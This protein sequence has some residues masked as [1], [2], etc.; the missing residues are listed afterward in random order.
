MLSVTSMKSD[1]GQDAR[2]GGREGPRRF[3]TVELMAFELCLGGCAGVTRQMVARRMFQ[4]GGL[5][6]GSSPSDSLVTGA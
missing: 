4:A 2:G 3:F 5:V 1:V 6:Q